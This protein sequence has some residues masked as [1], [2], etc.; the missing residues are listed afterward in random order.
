VASLKGVDGVLSRVYAFG[1]TNLVLTDQQVLVA[2]HDGDEI[3][4]VP[5]VLGAVAVT[6]NLPDLKAPLRFTGA[7]LGNIYLGK[8]PHWEDEA[9]TAATPG[10]ALPALPIRVV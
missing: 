9:E 2:Q 8:I 7:G 3:V 4:H 10:V 1:C 5:L 6:Y